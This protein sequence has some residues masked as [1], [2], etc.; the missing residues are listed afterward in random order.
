MYWHLVGIKLQ[1]LCHWRM[2]GLLAQSVYVISSDVCDYGVRRSLLLLE[3]QQLTKV[4]LD[5]LDRWREVIDFY[6]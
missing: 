5:R 3:T 6:L 2:L 1:S 4:N